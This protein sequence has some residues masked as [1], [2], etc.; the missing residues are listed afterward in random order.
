MTHTTGGTAG[1]RV[2]SEGQRPAGQRTVGK[3]M[4]PRIREGPDLQRRKNRTDQEQRAFAGRVVW[5]L[6]ARGPRQQSCCKQTPHSTRRATGAPRAPA[7]SSSPGPRRPLERRRPV[8]P[9][10]LR[11]SLS[12]VTEPSDKLTLS[13]ETD[14]HRCAHQ[15]PVTFPRQGGPS[16]RLRTLC[17]GQQGGR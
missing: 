3:G 9:P 6:E 13:P 2:L 16:S 14:T 17:E 12:G 10:R 15:G 1:S 11:G 8:I 5:D 4:I 7:H